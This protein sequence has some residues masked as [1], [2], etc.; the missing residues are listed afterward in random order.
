MMDNE[1]IKSLFRSVLLKMNSIVIELNG[2]KQYLNADIPIDTPPVPAVP[3]A[4]PFGTPA[5]PGLPSFEEMRASEAAG[6]AV[7]D[8]Q[9]A[10]GP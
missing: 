5:K 9:E 1:E 2:I 10:E 6:A 3:I 7:S 8:D 4:E